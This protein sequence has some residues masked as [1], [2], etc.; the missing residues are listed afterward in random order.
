MKKI[1]VALIG[2]GRRGKTLFGLLSGMANVSVVGAADPVEVNKN[3][4]NC[5]KDLRQLVRSEKPDVVIIATPPQI[6]FQNISLCN[7]LRVPVICEKPVVT[8]LRDAQLLKRFGIRIYPAYQLEYHPLISKAFEII[9][10]ATVL[11]IFA[12]QRVKNH[13]A[14]GKK[15]AS[16][17]TLLDNGSHLVQLAVSHFGL[18]RKVFA[19]VNFMAGGVER[20]VDA[21]LFYKNFS[22][23]IHAD[24]LSAIGKENRLDIFTNTHNIH[25]QETNQLNMLYRVVAL[26]KNGWTEMVRK[27]FFIPRGLERSIKTD[28]LNQIALIDPTQIMLRAFFNDISKKSS[29]FSNEKLSVAVDVTQVIEALYQSSEQRLVVS[30]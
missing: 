14:T 4:L 21:F 28:P 15:K 13:H 25:F 8:T 19:E 2:F 23:K 11:N 17:G 18:P 26:P 9:K 12:A 30:L 16:I 27:D 1:K 7:E 6:H 20:Q 24:W 29:R 3:L 10:E 22:F 5:Y